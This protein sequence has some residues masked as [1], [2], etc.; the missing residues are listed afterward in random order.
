MKKSKTDTPIE[1]F[2]PL[3]APL[4]IPTKKGERK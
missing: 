1:N 4:K 3:P 2:A